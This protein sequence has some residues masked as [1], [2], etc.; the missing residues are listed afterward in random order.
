MSKHKL[1]QDVSSIRPK[2]PDTPYRY[3]LLLSFIAC[4]FSFPSDD[5]FSLKI[6]RT[7]KAL[8][9]KELST[10]AVSNTCAL[11]NPFPGFPIDFRNDNSGWIDYDLGPDLI[12]THN[13]DGTK[14]ITGS[15]LNGTPVDFGSGIN[16]SACG[17]N[18]GWTLNLIL[19]DKKS[20]TEW[21]AEGGE[22]NLNG[23]CA[24]NLRENIDYWDINGT[25]TGTGCRTGQTVTVNGA[26]G[27]YRLQ[28]GIAG[29]Q[30]SNDC[31]AFGLSTW[32]NTVWDDGTTANQPVNSDIY[33]F[34]DETCYSV[35]PEA[36]VF[37][38][39]PSCTDNTPNA[40]G[41]LQISASENA[42]RVN[43]STGS[44]YTG[45]TDYNAATPIGALPFQFATGQSNPS[46]NRDYTVRVFNG[47]S[48]CY[49]DYTVTMN[50]QDCTVG[51]NCIENLYLNDVDLGEVHK[52]EV[53][54]TTGDIAEIGNPWISGFDSPHGLGVDLNGY[55][56]IGNHPSNGP[57]HKVT[58]DG[59]TIDPAWNTTIT[60]GGLTNIGSLDN[61]I[62]TNGAFQST[63]Y[64]NL[65]VLDACTGD[66]L[67]S[68]CLA[69]SNFGDWGMQV[70]DDGTVLVTEGIDLNLGFGAPAVKTVWK[71]RFD[72]GL[73]GNSTP[74]CIDPLVTGGYLNDYEEIYGITSD[75]S[76]LYMV[77][78]KNGGNTF[79]VKADA[80]TGAFVAEIDESTMSGTD[81]NNPGYNG[82]RGIIYAPSSDKLYVS[83]I[84]DCISVVEPSD[85]SYLGAG[86]GIVTN[87]EPKAIGILKECCPNNN[88]IV[89]DTTLCGTSLND[90]IFLQELIN[91]DGTIC[92]GFWEEGMTN[93]GL[94]YNDC[95]N[96]VT[97]NAATAC[98]TFTLASDGT[99]NNPRCGAFTITVNISVAEQ[100]EAAVFAIQPSCTNDTPGSDGYLQISSLASGARVNWS[101]GST[102]TGDPDF[103]DATNLSGVTFP[104]RLATGLGNPSGSQDYT[105][106]IF[107][108]ET[109]C[110]E[111]CFTDYTVTMNEQ[112]CSTTA[113]DCTDYVYVNDIENDVVHKFKVNPATGA[114]TELLRADGTPW[115]PAGNIDNPHGLAIDQ[116]GFLYIGE[117][118]DYSA[119]GGN[120]VRLD[121]DGNVL[122]PNYLPIWGYNMSSFDNYLIYPEPY[123][124]RITA[125]DLCTASRVGSIRMNPA[126]R[127]GTNWGLWVEPDGSIYSTD[128]FTLESNT[129]TGEIYYGQVGIGD[130]VTPP[131]LDLQPV[132]AGLPAATM[133][134]T[135]DPAGNMYVITGDRDAFGPA[136]VYKYDAGGNFL[137]SVTDSDGTDG[138]FWGS[139]GLVYS[140]ASGKLY[141]ASNGETCVGCMDPVTLTIDPACSAI[142][143]GSFG[144]KG[145]SVKKECCPTN[146]NVVIDTTLCAGVTGETIFLQDL[147]SCEGTVT[148]GQWTPAAGNTGLTFNSCNLSVTIDNPDACGT[149]VL[150]SDGTGNTKQC[151]AFR[152]TVNVSVSDVAITAA[153]TDCRHIGND[154][155]VADYDLTVTFNSLSCTPGEMLEVTA[156]GT[157]IATIDPAVQNSPATVT[158]TVPADGTGSHTFGAAYSVAGCSAD[159]QITAPPPCPQGVCPP[160]RCLPVQLT[161]N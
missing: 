9:A 120:T 81:V 28:I 126:T 160:Q 61:Y 65:Q 51:C 123:N 48:D 68:I 133:G 140:E 6:F 111:H 157:V 75:G 12:L 127:N 141:I 40:D 106:R 66:R 36:T 26:V 45:S 33:A 109:N 119:G 41:Y 97:V 116:N 77:A 147:V 139:R 14:S 89:I 22:A 15:I 80:N 83:G 155:F 99:G 5:V 18:D 56:Y 72:P 35:R 98:G 16:G 17:A 31:T 54:P 145:I 130:F 144:A 29:N 23:A 3:L 67:G 115:L 118:G 156:D 84:E 105:V 104:F 125:Y 132:V 114:L 47:A 154:E 39:Q 91:C 113:C 53:T 159:T 90:T 43:F 161:R 150:E 142:Y 8:V 24:T 76:H 42:D 32:L 4:A 100:P 124:D 134:I 30:G 101:V 153:Q 107:S 70:L 85:L 50:E 37:A 146:N 25:L 131:T 44:T 49:R 92:E 60:G 135:A 82:A 88:N 95:N 1:P 7:V 87:G 52:F 11:T 46:G 86:A 93:A 158:A 117:A 152:I 21:E 2:K 78:R 110:G 138:G 59:E 149:F 20:W 27:N 94:I 122:D 121:S 34:L 74:N 63:E 143:P 58:C 112:D 137:L 19:S 129:T 55:I 62:I 38:L 64:S 103:A 10:A 71:F 79:L 13:N 128:N 108:S 148:E 73:I 57:I 151:G 102:Y 136:T 96:S 69:G